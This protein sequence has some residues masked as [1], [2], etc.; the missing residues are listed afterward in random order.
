M[1]KKN[2][3][4]GLCVGLF[5]LASLVSCSSDDS[6][7]QVT[8]DVPVTTDTPTTD[9]PTTDTPTTDTPTTDTPGPTES[10]MRVIVAVFD[11]NGNA[12]NVQDADGNTTKDYVMAGAG[13]QHRVLI[14]DFTGAWCGWCPRVSHSIETLETENN[15]KIVAVALH[16]GDKLAFSKQGVLGN[17]LW[18]KFGVPTNQRGY[19]FAVIN[20]EVEWQAVNGNNMNLNQVLSKAAASSNIGIKITSNLESTSGSVNVSFKFAASY[21]S[22]LKY[23]V[24]I[25]QD[26]IVLAQE[27]Y[28][29]NYGGAGKKPNF[30][31]NSVA[32]ATT[33]DIFGVVI[34]SDQ[35]STGNEFN[36]G[37]LNITYKKF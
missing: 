21:T 32:K 4:K 34:P 16:N 27:N 23:V 11:N 33:G 15:D 17:S 3:F 8:T 18:E 13:Y 5:T 37:Q 19:P 2:L 26:G 14:E 36:T 1:N 25:V 6:K 28:T 24:Y 20:R 9:T 31:H 30:I 12:L 22:E 35:T 10:N 7:T 29:T